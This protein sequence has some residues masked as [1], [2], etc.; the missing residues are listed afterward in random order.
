MYNKSYD[1]ECK[2]ELL[3]LIENGQN[4]G[5]LAQEYGVPVK[6]IRQWME[7]G[8]STGTCLRERGVTRNK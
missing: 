5:D 8:G 6:T 1:V 4:V 2:L 3:E 7:G